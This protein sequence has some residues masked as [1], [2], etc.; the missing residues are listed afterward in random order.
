MSRMLRLTIAVSDDA[1][2]DMVKLAL[3]RRV[4]SLD[5]LQDLDPQPTDQAPHAVQTN[6]QPQ[7]DPAA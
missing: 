6:D 5:E 7:E 1:T 2:L 3:H 4:D